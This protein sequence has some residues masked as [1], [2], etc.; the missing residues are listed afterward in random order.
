MRQGV[1]VALLALLA[2]PAFADVPSGTCNTGAFHV[3]APSQRIWECV[4]TA[5]VEKTRSYSSAFVDSD[6]DGTAEVLVNGVAVE[7]NPLD[8]STSAWQLSNTSIS[9]LG[10]V[11]ARFGSSGGIRIRADLDNDGLGGEYVNIDAN[12][13]GVMDVE[14]TAD[15]LTLNNNAGAILFGTCGASECI[16]FDLDDDGVIEATDVCMV[17]AGQDADC[18]GTAD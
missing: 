13:D 9:N 18:D 15:R 7:I 4:S 1:I 10:D 11:E 5:W 8:G 3:D 14:I 2:I 16:C 12:G 17:D 6:N